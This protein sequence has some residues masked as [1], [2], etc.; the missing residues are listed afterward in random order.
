MLCPLAGL[1]EL[2]Y[3]VQNK[4][5]GVLA[6]IVSHSFVARVEGGFV[7]RIVP[8][9]FLIIDQKVS[10]PNWAPVVCKVLLV[11]LVVLRL[12]DESQVEVREHLIFR[13]LVDI[14]CLNY[15]PNLLLLG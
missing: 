15:T 9:L 7:S 3:V 13:F 10:R 5:L 8:C 11:Y 1:L 4:F 2:N 6:Q 14:P 12:F